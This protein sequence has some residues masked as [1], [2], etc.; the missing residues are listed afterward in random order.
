MAEIK[1]G[2]PAFPQPFWDTKGNSGIVTAD[3]VNAGGMTLRDYFAAKILVALLTRVNDV[4][5]DYVTN[6]TPYEGARDAY[7][8][9][10]AMLR[11]REVN[12]G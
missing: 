2:G 5:G 10:D 9:A 4:T 8:W 6:A 12:H 7:H 1:D 11:A 3:E